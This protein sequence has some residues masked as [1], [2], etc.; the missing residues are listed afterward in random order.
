MARQ[1]LKSK[2]EEVSDEKANI[3]RSNNNFEKLMETIRNGNSYQRIQVIPSLAHLDHPKVVP[4]LIELLKDKDSLVRVYSAQQLTRLADERSTDAIVAA[5]QD[6]NE[7]VRKYAAETLLKIGTSEHVPALVESVIKNFPDQVKPEI[8][9]SVRVML[10]AIGK[11]T[12]KA[13]AR[14]VN[15]LSEITGEKQIHQNMWWHY[16][17]VGICL[18]KTGDKSTYSELKRVESILSNSKQDYNAWY[19][20]RKA[21]GSVGPKTDSFN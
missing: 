21:L 3:K 7:N 15:L 19:A 10:E 2:V 20:F 14:I 17:S 1:K 5:L 8:D 18:E 16:E 9:W 12:R 13:P 6:N 4:V 11:L